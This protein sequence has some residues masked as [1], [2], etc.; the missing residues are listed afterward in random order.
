MRQVNGMIG[1]CAA[2]LL[3]ASA[4]HGVVQI[5]TGTASGSP[6]SQVDVPVTIQRNGATVAVFGFQL[7]AGTQLEA[8]LEPVIKS[9][10][11]DEIDCTANSAVTLPADSV[12]KGIFKDAEDKIVM[13]FGD[14][15][16]SNG[17][18]NFDVDGTVAFCK[19]KIKDSATPG[20]VALLCN[21]APGTA[22]SSDNEGNEPETEC[23][24]GL[25][26]IEE[27][28]PSPTPTETPEEPTATPTRL[29]GGDEDDDG[30]Q[31]V[32]PQQAH[33]GWLLLIPAALL[34]LRRRRAR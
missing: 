5:G 3:L 20:E 4:A 25:V 2:G 28:P 23:V 29:P 1:M 13:S 10:T 18:D 6:G 21:P 22:S 7:L 17:I 33:A 32:A 24:D 16:A 30:C 34:V 14:T 9:G 8:A 12:P 26:T 15:N 19:F 11:E 27:A 31:V